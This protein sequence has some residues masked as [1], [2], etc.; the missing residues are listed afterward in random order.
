MF[1]STSQ[2]NA[3]NVPRPANKVMDSDNRPALIIR[4]LVS[5]ICLIAINAAVLRFPLGSLTRT[6]KASRLKNRPATYS[7]N[8][9]NRPPT[10]DTHQLMNGT[11]LYDLELGLNA[12]VDKRIGEIKTMVDQRGSDLNGA[13]EAKFS[14][15]RRLLEDFQSEF[16][17]RIADLKT[18]TEDKKVRGIKESL[19]KLS[20]NVAEIN[21]N[22]SNV[23]YVFESDVTE[24]LNEANFGKKWRSQF[25]FCRGLFANETGFLDSRSNDQS[26]RSNDLT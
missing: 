20:E 21:V 6:G 11:E 15:L 4:A 5:V 13:I 16:D 14:S 19:Q 25:F 3:M 24:L 7:F 26:N 23:T 12:T 1:A 9:K 18:K 2:P 17:M 22:K 8:R 10:K